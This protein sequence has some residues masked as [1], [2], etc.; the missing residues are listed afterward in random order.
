MERM[1]PRFND[2]DPDDE[3]L[4]CRGCGGYLCERSEATPQLVKWWN[5]WTWCP[6]HA[7]DME[8]LSKVQ[9]VDQ[10]TR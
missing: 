1:D 5:G 6:E 3:A 9:P 7:D 10:V 4:F 2:Q 8:S